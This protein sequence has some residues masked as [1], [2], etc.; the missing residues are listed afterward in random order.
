MFEWFWGGCSGATIQTNNSSLDFFQ[1]QKHVD[2][3]SNF[4]WVWR[5]FPA[6]TE[7]WELWVEWRRFP[8]GCRCG[9]PKLSPPQM[10][11][12]QAGSKYWWVSRVWRLWFRAKATTLISFV[13]DD[14]SKA[15]HKPSKHL[16]IWL[17]R[18]FYWFKKHHDE[19]WTHGYLV[20]GWTNP[21]EKNMRTVKLDPR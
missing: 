19:W 7:K 21:F 6:E 10:V 3:S 18:W 9:T 20:G 17:S 5:P 8:P 11:W 1:L 12:Y 16:M 13:Y 2:L 4:W 15:S 14:R